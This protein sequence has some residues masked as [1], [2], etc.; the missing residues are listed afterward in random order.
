[1][2]QL[3]I[4][5]FLLFI[6][7]SL[8]AQLQV[9][10]QTFLTGPIL[11]AVTS[12]ETPVFFA[13][14]KGNNAS[15]FEVRIRESVSGITHLPYEL[16]P[17]CK[18]DSC[19]YIAN[20]ANLPIEKELKVFIYRNNSITAQGLTEFSIP[21]NNVVND[22]NFLIGSCAAASSGASTR[23]NIFP[24][25][26]TE[27]A[28]FMLWL[29]DMVY[30]PY[31][32]D[33]L[34]AYDTYMRYS[35]QSPKRNQLFQSFFHFGMWDD[36]DYSYNNATAD[37]SDKAYT[38]SLFKYWLPNPNYEHPGKTGGIYH[39]YKYRDVE[40]FN[41]D[42]RYYKTYNDHLGQEQLDWL[43]QRLLQSNA[44]FKFIQVGTPVLERK[45]DDSNTE[46]TMWQTG[47]R[48]ELFEFIYDNNIEGVI[49]LTGDLHRSHFVKYNPGCNST[50]PFYEFM[51]SPLTSGQSGA[52]TVYSGVFYESNAHSYGKISV[53]GP[54]G[55]RSV[56]LEQR[57]V[58]GTVLGSFSINEDELKFSGLADD[59]PATALQAHYPLDN[60]ANDISGNAY[61]GTFTGTN[62]AA[63][64]DRFQSNAD[65]MSITTGGSQ[66]KTIDLPNQ[67]LNGLMDVTIAFWAKPTILQCGIVSAAAPTYGNEILIYYGANK[68]YSLWTKNNAFTTK[69]SFETNE[70]HH[71]VATRRGSTGLAQL[72]VNGVFRG[73]E[74][75]P[76]GTMNVS[77]LLCLNDQDGSTGGGNLD[78]DQQFYGDI[79]DL[80]I[81]NKTLCLYQI[82]ELYLEG[83]PKLTAV[84]SPLLCNPPVSATFEATGTTNGN[85]RWYHGEHTPNAINTTNSTVT[86]TLNESKTLWASA[87][88]PWQSSERI[89]VSIEVGPKVYT[90]ATGY[91]SPVD[92]TASFPITGNGNE[93][94]GNYNALSGSGTYL[95]LGR[96]GAANSAYGFNSFP[97]ILTVPHQTLDK[98]ERATVSF[99]LKTTDNNCGVFSAAS[100]VYGNLILFFINTD[101]HAVIWMNN[102]YRTFR[103][104]GIN[105]GNWHHVAMVLD[106]VNALVNPYLD[107]VHMEVVT[108]GT[109]FKPRT[110]DIP[111]GALVFGND[112]DGAGG[113]GYQTSQQFEG[114][115]DEIKL[116]RRLLS[117]DEIETLAALEDVVQQ[118]FQVNATPTSLCE[119]DTTRIRLSP[120]QPG[121]DYSLA[122]QGGSPINAA[123]Y[124]DA[125]T[126]VFEFPVSQ[127][128]GVNLVAT[129]PITGC[130][131][132]FTTL[133]PITVAGCLELEGW[134]Q[135]AYEQPTGV[136]HDKLRQAN[137]IP[138]TGNNGPLLPELL[139]I[140]GTKAVVDWIEIELRDA[141]APATVMYSRSGLLLSDG[142]IIAEDGG[143]LM[144][145]S[146][147]SGSFYVMLKH[148]NHLPAMT[149][150]PIS[151]PVSGTSAYNFKVNYGYNMG[152]GQS[153]VLLPNGEYGMLLGD[154]DPN[155]VAGYDLNGADLIK[156]QGEN[157]IFNNYLQGD[158]N[159]NGDVNGQ[160][161]ALMLPNNGV[162]ST[163]PR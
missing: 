19:A 18:G 54:A 13:I 132:D 95:T 157:G 89:P 110:F 60:S 84:T 17:F 140:T 61:N 129:D 40:F 22:F 80:R 79:D 123:S 93:E 27:D 122:A 68:Q 16:V 6:S 65:A 97:D 150:V 43:K 11:G 45:I 10:G 116:Y 8:S 20:F 72:Y 161:K 71:V 125:D 39:S 25:M 143:R 99:W 91:S 53:T 48:A 107:G 47:E 151:L 63:T 145:P 31:D 38:A 67:A 5:M 7:L 78:P 121:I 158:F 29:G 58:S 128:V 70:W 113:G 144:F 120:L 76:V 111:P 153:Q 159:L 42:V 36:H 136:M 88:T 130:S 152:L 83:I 127:S 74:V 59:D 148:R 35:T 73:E 163:V 56:R 66:L 55:N 81:Y 103:S 21:N 12:A 135:G 52:H 146:N 147:V 33:T 90:D 51:S 57:N 62:I 108:W 124:M 77:S 105:D 117:E 106:G 104:P 46:T 149:D 37:Y 75:H 115:I 112:Q 139:T 26:A 138:L 100:P 160:D 4:A 44:T 32:L 131:D 1:M 2:K 114:S 134:L 92:L 30:L 50:Y 133:Y 14:E 141:S 15:Q 137:L 87:Y 34:I 23:E 142:T 98:A 41:T 118:P 126:L 82:E 3:P 102:G 86:L 28:E 155:G 162:F 156:W 49:F 96:D 9:S 101:G 109:S 94:T 85:Y 69:D 24:Q 154:G 64:A 119:D